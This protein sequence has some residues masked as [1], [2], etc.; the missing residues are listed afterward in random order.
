MSS[1]RT[2]TKTIWQYSETLPESTMEFLRGIAL[3][4]SKVKNY[5][6]KRYSGIKSLGR[7]TPV[8]DIMS[9]VRHSGIRA[10]LGLPSAYFDPAII[11]AVAD[12]KGMW[13]MLKKRIGTLITVNENLG[14]ADRIY[15]RTVLKL[16][17][18]YAA[19]LCHEQYEMPRKA[20]K[21][22]IDVE[23]L[24]NLLRRLTRKYLSK[25][26]AGSTE[27][28]SMTP[29]GYTYKSGAICL[30]S[31]TAGKRIPLPLKDS[32][33][34]DRQ[35]RVCIK[36]D[37]VALAIPLET[38]IRKHRDYA[39]TVYIHI[40]Y[41]D[42]FTLSNGNVY[43][44]SLGDMTSLETQRL[45]VKNKERAVMRAA[46]RQSVESG[47]RERAGSI[48]SNNLGTQK[49]DR[50]KEK[51]RSKTQSFINTEINRMFASEKPQRI[52][53]TKPITINKTKLP[54]KTANRNMTRNFNGYVR[55]RLAY[56]CRL[57]AIELVEINSKGTGVLCS[58][59][60]AEGVRRPDGFRCP[61]CG[62][63]AS[64]SLNGAKNIESKYNEGNYIKSNNNRS[65]IT[66]ERK[67]K[68]K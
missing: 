55:E 57:N 16:D 7:L 11:E 15:L 36:K 56:K 20:E 6:Y 58:C 34:C 54:S 13:G 22:D 43:G 26:E 28:F 32:K 65:N 50:R 21:L 37:Y 24:N 17:K 33:I 67:Q 48:E 53:I 1:E 68:V 27:C 9:E 3:D 59:C 4:Y 14:D 66:T 5:V 44:Q 51:E 25:P 62:Y 19:V 30:A 41:Q 38:K 18:I 52:V 46:Y 40:G 23:H 2:I 60:G 12:I 49:Y 39:S 63:Q 42:M 29:S 47:D 61:S 45:T 64:L 31:R 35:I 10:Q 8:F